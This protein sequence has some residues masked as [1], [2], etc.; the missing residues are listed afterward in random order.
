MI[1]CCHDWSM[2][3]N[4]PRDKPVLVV[5]A[6]KILGTCDAPHN[7]ITSVTMKKKSLLL[8]SCRVTVTKRSRQ[9]CFG[10]FSGRIER[11]AQNLDVGTEGDEDL[12]WDNPAGQLEAQAISNTELLGKTRRPRP[13]SP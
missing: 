4:R 8:K 11:Q 3:W 7:T 9:C 5:F 6:F 10:T 1:R 12:F 13:R 2:I